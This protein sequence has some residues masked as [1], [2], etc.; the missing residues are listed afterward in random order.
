VLIWI[1]VARTQ[2]EVLVAENVAPPE[3]T[4]DV[5][6]RQVMLRGPVSS[7]AHESILR[8][9]TFTL[10][11]DK[12]A[13][14]DLRERPALPPGWALVSELALRAAAET[15]S[16]T[17]VISTSRIHINGI[18][19]DA[20]K[21]HKSLSSVERNLLPGMRL[22]DQIIE[23]RPAGSLHRQCVSLFRRAL[24]GRKIEFPL[25]SATLRSSAAPLL[26]ELVQIAADCPDANIIITG[27]TDNTGQESGNLA[28]SQSRADAIANYM[29]A[30]GIL[31]NRITAS[32]VGSS[33]PLV[34]DNTRQAHQ[35]NRRI[36]IDIAFPES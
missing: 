36:D 22:E 11:P 8:Q 10:F 17:I 2:E 4:I 30:S 12:T 9:R 25:A 19:N 23:I 28:L 14:F 16:A 35:L 15:Y 1:G 6:K 24:G 33:H 32:G 7:V 3:F 21:W 31:A 18:T 29:I 26:D 34:D 27:H 13:S 5:S 20:E